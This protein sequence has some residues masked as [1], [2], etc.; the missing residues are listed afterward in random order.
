MQTRTDVL[1]KLNRLMIYQLAVWALVAIVTLRLFDERALILG[2][3]VGNAVVLPWQISAMR[4]GLKS[5]LA[6]L[7]EGT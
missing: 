5:E 6:R 7:A 4:A 2:Q 3:V 1:A